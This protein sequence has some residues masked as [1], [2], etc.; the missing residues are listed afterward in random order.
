MS[1]CDDQEALKSSRS[2]RKR[3]SDDINTDIIPKKSKGRHSG[4]TPTSNKDSL[5]KEV[6]EDPQWNNGNESSGNYIS[7]SIMY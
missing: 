4:E 5:T 6:F 2:F 1:D 3:K 7:C